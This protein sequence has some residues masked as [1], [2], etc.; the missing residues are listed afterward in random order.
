MKNYRLQQKKIGDNLFFLE[1]K[2]RYFIMNTYP[3]K[4][5][6]IEE[7]ISEPNSFLTD[8]LKTD[9]FENQDYS[10]FGAVE[11][12]ATTRCNLMCKHCTARTFDN[13]NHSFYGMP[14][15]DMTKQKMQKAV[16][17]AINQLN[18]R[19]ATNFS[20]YI[21][22]EMFIT[23]GEPL[24]VWDNI[25]STL[26]FTVKELKKIQ[27]IKEFK[28]NPHIV[29][30][31][32]LITDKIAKELKENDVIVTVALDSPYNE[33]R[34]NKDNYSAT[35]DAIKGLQKLIKVGHK[36][37]SVNVVIAGEKMSIIDKVFDYL[38]EKK[39][40][41]GISA[42]QLSAL[43]P[44]IQHTEYANKGLSIKENTGF[45][46]SSNCLL[47]S[48]K[49]IEYSFKYKTDMK[50]YSSKLSSNLMQ[51]GNR[52]RCPVAEWKWC[53]VPNG[54]I[55]ACHQLVGIDKFKLGNIDMEDW[56][57]SNQSKYIRKLFTERTVFKADLC[58]D[59]VLST[60]CMVFVDCP[61][62]SYLE[63]GDINKVPK[64]YCLCGKTYLETLLGEHIINLIDFQEVNNLHKYN[65]Y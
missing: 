35:P 42:I 9:S 13:D 36:K 28:F 61:A 44:P 34:I 49:L 37:T 26:K 59:C 7:P 2:E 29:T 60:S 57:T 16:I 15:M 65:N 55:Y 20:E 25:L 45:N 52:Y 46:N 3:I 62:R 12:V 64:H 47:F 50:L 48:E 8:Y 30:N 63:E 27:N 4:I 54:D 24:L 38:K 10:G 5:I 56:Y 19:Q 23:G 33:V 32:V 53:I 31:G 6:E 43:A 39:A 17:S 11:F 22:F 58:A 21:N 51:G 40:F 18:E 41:E 1:Y 14:S